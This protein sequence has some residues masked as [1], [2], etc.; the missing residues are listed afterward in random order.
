MSFSCVYCGEEIASGNPASGKVQLAGCPRCLNAFTISWV[1]GDPAPREIE[2]VERVDRLAPAGSVMAGVLGMLDEVLPQLP[3][4]PHVPQRALA[5]IHDPLASMRQLADLVNE[6]AAISMKILRICNSAMYMSTSEVKDLQLACARLGMKTIANITYAVTNGNLYRSPN[7]AL[8]D[9]MEQMWR[10]AMATAHAADALA[11]K[12]QGIDR[13][14]PFIAGL[15]HDI[16]KLVLLDTL[17]NKYKGPVGRLRQTPELMIKA[18]DLF[19]PTVGLQVVQYWRMPNEFAFSTYYGGTPDAVGE[20][21]WRPLAHIVCL[22]SA[23][24]DSSG[25]PIG[26]PTTEL[27]GHASVAALGLS[28]DVVTGVRDGLPETVESLLNALGAA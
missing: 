4:L 7:P 26:E 17:A 20:A 5:L 2:N 8:R 18:I 13:S 16:G 14:L 24:A 9:L 25:F 23:I 19:H 28:Q 15:I 27:E 12:T 3:V 6:D 11:E 22:A 10:H 1:N 21:Q